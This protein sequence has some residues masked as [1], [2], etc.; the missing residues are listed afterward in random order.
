M[1]K[2]YTGLPLSKPDPG[3]KGA[4]NW[5]PLLK[6]RI[7]ANHQSTPILPAVVDSGSPYCL[8]RAD[9][10][11]FLHIDLRKAPQG[12][13]GGIIGGPHDPVFFHNVNVVVENNWTINVYA[14]FMKKLCTAAILGRG[15]F[16]D[17]FQVLFDHSKN[18]PEFEVTKIEWTN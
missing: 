9:V 3:L 5:T 7:S 13:L 2:Q 11:D 8:F 15:G 6:V 10:A 12:S 16:F 4:I 1:R 14:C 17:R 18:P